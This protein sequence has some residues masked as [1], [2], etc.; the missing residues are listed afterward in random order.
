MVKKQ[1]LQGMVREAGRQG[2]RRAVEVSM[3]AS[4]KSGAWRKMFESSAREGSRQAGRGAG[5]GAT[6]AAGHAARQGTR[7]EG[8]EASKQTTEAAARTGATAGKDGVRASVGAGEGAAKPGLYR[9]MMDSAKAGGTGAAEGDLHFFGKHMMKVPKFLMN[10]PVLAI[11]GYMALKGHASGR[12]AFIELGDTANK[13]FFPEK[14]QDKSLLENSGRAVLDASMGEGTFDKVRDFIHGGVDAVR[15]G[16]HAA[17]DG[18]SSGGWSFPAGG[19]VGLPVAA[20]Q[21]TIL[22]IGSR[23][24]DLSQYSE[25][26]Q[27][28]LRAYAASINAQQPTTGMALT[29]QMGQAFNPM[30]SFAGLLQSL[31]SGGRTTSAAAMI[32]AAMLMF[33]NYGWM[34]K[35][36]SV[37][38]A[39]FAYKNVQHLNEQQASTALQQLAQRGMSQGAVPAVQQL[40][41]RNSL[42]QIPTVSSTVPDEELPQFRSSLRR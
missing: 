14:D 36:A 29:Q 18:L 20:P 31:M 3:A 34:A 42:S 6:E 39:S 30:E 38:L 7:Q 21:N 27:A 40:Q 23:Q 32:P 19:E 37:M 22:T 41:G 11:G 28:R 12:G 9:R 35:I 8:K 10:H 16:L 4:A 15:D 5:H 24:V 1:I 26:E 2:A 33:G 17:K 13:W 25:E